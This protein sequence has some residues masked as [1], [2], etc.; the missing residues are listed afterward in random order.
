VINSSQREKQ[1]GVFLLENYEI[2]SK[3]TIVTTFFERE[4][5]NISGVRIDSSGFLIWKSIIN[6]M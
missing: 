6:R 2:K 3:K 1:A 4:Y 5:S